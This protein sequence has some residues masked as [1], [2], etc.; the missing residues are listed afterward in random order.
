M[1]VK[2]ISK[3]QLDKFVTQP[4]LPAGQFLQSSLWYEFQ[5][6]LGRK[7][8]ALGVFNGESLLAT[9]LLV[10]YNFPMGKRYFNCI[11]GPVVNDKLNYK[12]QMSNVK[13]SSNDQMSNVQMS[14]STHGISDS[15]L[16]IIYKEIVQK[17]A[18]FLCENYRDKN[19]LFIRVESPV[20]GVEFKKWC[21]GIGV[22]KVKTVWPKRTLVLD[23]KK[24]EDQLLAEMHHKWRYNIRL[25]GRK[26]VVIEKCNNIDDFYV[27]AKET[28]KRDNLKFFGRN[29][30]AKLWTI[31]EKNNVGDF[32][33]AKYNGQLISAII[34]V[35]RGNTAVY[36]YGASA[37]VHRNL[38]PNHLIQWHAIKEAKARGCEW[39]DFWGI[40][41]KR[42]NGRT[43]ERKNPDGWAGITRFKRGFGGFE[44]GYG[45]SY[46]F[47][48]HKGW[49]GLYQVARR[50]YKI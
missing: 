47:I 3:E 10:Q 35:Y 21:K 14:K 9:C 15:K 11:R 26:G 18:E 44:V 16:Q 46:D 2:E 31:L 43:E 1:L 42:K 30:F 39:Y 5:E 13:S 19:V 34:N 48:M 7:C 25:S 22:K 12:C 45:Q 33:V 41:D 27:L 17:I 49:Y 6:S 8:L 23:L 36:F 28:E 29:Y 38:M 40:S 20:E 37:N 24:S 32:F 50:F 4:A